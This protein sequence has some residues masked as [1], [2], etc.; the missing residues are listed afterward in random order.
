MIGNSHDETSFS[1]KLLLTNRHVLNLGQAFANYNS[2]DIK[3]SKTHLSKTIQS[4]GSLF[5]LLGPSSKT[6]LL[7]IK[8]LAKPLAKSALIPSVLT[9]TA[10]AADAGIYKKSLRLCS[11]SLRLSFA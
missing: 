8:N 11:S 2:A 4:E 5:R 10:W 3:L 7:L 6:G 1:H 9:A